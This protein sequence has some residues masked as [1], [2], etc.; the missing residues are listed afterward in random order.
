MPQ[1]LWQEHGP[2]YEQ[3]CIGELACTLHSLA[4]QQQ[5][6][7]ATSS[8]I[9]AN[10]PEHHKESSALRTCRA[11]AT[12]NGFTKGHMGSLSVASLKDARSEQRTA[13][14]GTITV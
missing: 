9:S 4:A 1:V 11:A 3:S 8:M 13:A 5:H 12:I 14:T 7:Q 6:D 2:S 10:S